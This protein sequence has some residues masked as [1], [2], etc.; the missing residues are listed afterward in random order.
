M[1]AWSAHHR[2]GAAYSNVTPQGGRVVEYTINTGTITVDNAI[3]RATQELPADAREIWS[4]QKGHCYQVE[5][6]SRTVGHARAT[7]AA[8]DPGGGILAMINTLLPDGST[9]YRPAGVNEI[10]LSPG[11]Y[12]A[13]A[14]APDC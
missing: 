2:S 11:S 3:K 1:A 12:P 10:M 13:A 6:T 4:A 7:P 14:D 5:L 9:A 8:A